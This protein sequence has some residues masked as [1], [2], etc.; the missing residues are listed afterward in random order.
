LRVRTAVA[1]GTDDTESLQRGADYFGQPSFL[2]AAEFRVL[3]D[4]GR[5]K[6]H[7]EHYRRG[8]DG[9][10]F[11]RVLTDVHGFEVVEQH[12]GTGLAIFGDEDAVVRRVLAVR[13]PP[14]G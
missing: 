13:R 11:C 2:L 3:A 8:L 1:F 14:P 4:G 6:A 9:A 12:E 7:A 5:P 10:A